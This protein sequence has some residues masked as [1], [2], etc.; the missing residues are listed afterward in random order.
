MERLFVPGRRGL[1]APGSATLP[2]LRILSDA[3]GCCFAIRAGMSSVIR[4]L[5]SMAIAPASSK[6]SVVLEW[7]EEDRVWVSHVPGLG[8]LSTYGETRDEVLEKTREAIEGYLEAALAA[9]IAVTAPT[10]PPEIVEL[11][12]SQS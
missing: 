9:G 6:F 1:N 12:V 7:D 4:T 10:L 3:A 2:A 11:Q 8:H 5:Q